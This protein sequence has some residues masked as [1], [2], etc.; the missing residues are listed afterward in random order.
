MEE[1]YKK[2]HVN[3]LFLGD[4]LVC[5]IGAELDGQMKPAALPHHSA[6]SLAH[7]IH[8]SVQWAS[9]GI[10]GAG[11]DEIQREG[12]PKLREKTASISNDGVIVVVVVVGA[13]DLRTGNVMRYRLALR[14]L[15]HELKEFGGRSVDGVFLPCLPIADAPMLQRYP[16]QFFLGPVS[17][18]WERE[19]KKA[20]QHFEDAKVLPFPSLAETLDPSIFFSA[21]QMHPSENG[22]QFW[23]KSIAQEINRHLCR[24][25]TQKQAQQFDI[26][27]NVALGMW[28]QV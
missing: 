2:K 12:L 14:S 19:K 3:L 22:Y 24:R 27:Q 16:L 17:C 28:V 9:V 8:G 5:G 6:A 13:N 15:V 25:N 1:K 18:L 10:K 20:V 23:A 26:L 7:E 4:S 11:V 21:D